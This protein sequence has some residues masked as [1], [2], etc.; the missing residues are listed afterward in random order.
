MAR[1][2]QFVEFAQAYGPRLLRAA[3]LLTGDHHQAEDAAQ[4]ALARTYASWSRVRNNDAFAYARTVLANLV[5]DQWRRPIRETPQEY[6]PERPA[7]GDVADN[8][9]RQQ[10]LIDA[11]AE[12]NIRE[13]TVVVLRHF[14]DL[15]EAEVARE[16]GI[17]VGTVKSH[18]SR[19]LAKL[20]LTVDRT[21]TGEPPGDDGN[22][23]DNSIRNNPGAR[24]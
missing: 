19:A 6:L 24:K 3:Y 20:R 11:L 8:V 5:K 15:T 23:N 2:D 4:A 17:P 13:R 7:I 10:W 22:R 21:G 14:F 9:A 12:L 16:L 1:A 18:N